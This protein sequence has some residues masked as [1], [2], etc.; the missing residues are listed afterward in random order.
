MLAERIFGLSEQAFSIADIAVIQK[1]I[2]PPDAFIW[3]HN[4]VL[5]QRFFYVVKGTI[6]FDDERP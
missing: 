6:V 4:M 3:S 2:T 5:Y 1:S